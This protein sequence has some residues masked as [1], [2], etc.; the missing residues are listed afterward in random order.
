[1][2]INEGDKIPHLLEEAKF[3]S[4]VLQL[5]V[6]RLLHIEKSLKVVQVASLFLELTSLDIVKTNGLVSLIDGFRGGGGDVVWALFL[7][8]H[9]VL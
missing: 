5:F 8:F 2:E 4:A 7:E 9:S 6:R 1:M 3:R